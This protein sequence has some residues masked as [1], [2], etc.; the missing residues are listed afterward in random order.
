MGRGGEGK[1]SSVL[2]SLPS[3]LSPFFF[4]KKKVKGVLKNER[5][6]TCAAG[7][8]TLILEFGV[9]SRLTNNDIYETVAKRAMME[10]WDR[11]SP[12]GL[13]GNEIDMVKGKV[14]GKND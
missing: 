1:R 8:G 9:L 5:H 4:K 13:V 3:S 10:V 7:A 12:L 11:R 6:L 2:T 14:R